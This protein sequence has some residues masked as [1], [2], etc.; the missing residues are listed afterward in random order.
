MR[1][2]RTT[3]RVTGSVRRK[4]VPAP[5][6]LCT[7]TE[8]PASCTIDCTTFRPTPRPETALTDSRVLKPGRKRNSSN[9]ASESPAAVSR[10]TSPRV[11]TRSRSSSELDA[12]S[13]VLH[14]DHQPPVLMAR[15]DAQSRLGSL[16][17]R[18]SLSRRLNA[19]VD[20]VGD[21]VRDR[22]FQPL[23]N[24]AIDARTLAQH[25]KPHLLAQLARG[26]THQPRRSP[27]A[28]GERPQ[29]PGQNAAVKVLGGAL[30]GA[31]DLVELRDVHS[32]GQSLAIDLPQ[33]RRSRCGR[34]LRVLK[35]LQCACDGMTPALE[36]HTITC[37]RP[38]GHQGLGGH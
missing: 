31:R 37:Q 35:N 16:A 7:T 18:H 19:V 30:V 20:G 33:R 3:E 29:T 2:T 4:L 38:R 6:S 15:M 14:R 17:L 10:E 23:Q 34:R 21:Q 36:L 5:G 9:S 13:V 32:Q 12:A 8:P 27:D 25:L 22:R 26:I 28:L 11:T 24:V 1:M